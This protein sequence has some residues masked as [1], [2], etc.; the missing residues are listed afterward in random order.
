M[1]KL[2]SK[3]S[4]DLYKRCYMYNKVLENNFDTLF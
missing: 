1:N 4:I 3:V 2:D